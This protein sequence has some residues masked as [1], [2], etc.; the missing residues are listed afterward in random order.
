MN[1]DELY[2][3]S[4]ERI[5]WYSTMVVWLGSMVCVSSVMVGEALIERLPFWEAMIVGFTAYSVLMVIVLLQSMQSCDLGVPA[6]VAAKASMG[7]NGVRYI[8]SGMVTLSLIGWFGVQTNVCTNALLSIYEQSYDL[9]LPRKL[10]SLILGILM[11]LTGAYGFH[12]IKKLN[13]FAVPFLLFT[14]MYGL[15]RILSIYSISYIFNY[16]P[17]VDSS[18]G[19]GVSL[20]LGSFMLG[21]VISGDYS[22]FNKNRIDVIKSCVIGIFPVSILLMVTGSVIGLTLKTYDISIALS[23]LGMPVLGGCSLVLASWTTNSTNAYSG[24]LSLNNLFCWEANKREKATLLVGLFGTLLAMAEIIDFFIEYLLLLS[25]LLPA[26]TGVM[27]ADYWIVRKV[28]SNND[29]THFFPKLGVF[30]WG[31]GA[32]SSFAV[33]YCPAITSIMISLLCYLVFFE[34]FKRRFIT[35]VQ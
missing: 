35:T 28:H 2:I 4:K 6:L 23:E 24:G 31:I 9:E 33:D 5:P 26:V 8:I 19:E 18:W 21:A 14:L 16:A 22:R 1:Y 11:T 13:Y 32:S 7:R 15:Y 12:T 29:F 17:S 10:V 25:K 34:I 3:P 20:V 30:A 27:I